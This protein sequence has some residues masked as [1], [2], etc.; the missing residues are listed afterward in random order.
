MLIAISA[1]A[2]SIEAQATSISR[3]RITSRI[4]RLSTST[5]YID[6]STVSGSIPWLIVRLPCGSMSTASTRCPASAKATARLRVVVVFATPPFWLAKAITFAWPVPGLGLLYLRAG[7]CVRREAVAV[8]AATSFLC[9][10]IW[11]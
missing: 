1:P 7:A 2:R 9:G 8:H 6:F 4:E 3:L 10:G 5:W 11:E